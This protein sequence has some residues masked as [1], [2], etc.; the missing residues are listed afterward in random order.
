M[1]ITRHGV[2]ARLSQAVVH[3]DTI[4]LAGMVADDKTLPAGSQTRQILEKL[5][6]LLKT[7]NSDATRLLSATIYLA[8]MRH[9]EEMNAA[10]TAYFEP[11]NLPARATIGVASLGPQVLVE[12]VAIAAARGSHA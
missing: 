1:S 12:V 3:G 5:D 6:A 10:W 8:E 4:Y 11:R 9:K 2:G 7:L